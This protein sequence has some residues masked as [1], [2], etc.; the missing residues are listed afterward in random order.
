VGQKETSGLDESRLVGEGNAVGGKFTG[1]FGFDGIG[2]KGR[3]RLITFLQHLRPGDE[4]MPLRIQVL[5]SPVHGLLFRGHL[6]PRRESVKH[7]AIKTDPKR[8]PGNHR[9][10]Q[11]RGQATIHSFADF[12]TQGRG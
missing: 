5:K 1:G 11:T 6:P 10:W 12:R 8:L 7:P 2:R 4:A 9:H 3:V